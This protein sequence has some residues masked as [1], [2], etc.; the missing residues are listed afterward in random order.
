MPA[1]RGSSSSPDG[2]EAVILR[3]GGCAC[4]CWLAGATSTIHHSDWRIGLTGGMP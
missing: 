4:A 2:G 1:V 3:D